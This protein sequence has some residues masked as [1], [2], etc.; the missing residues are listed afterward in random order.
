MPPEYMIRGEISNKHDIF[1]LGVIII[2]II[3]GPEGYSKYRDTTTPQ[4]FIELVREFYVYDM[5]GSIDL[6]APR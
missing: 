4:E 3:T 5:L 1:S 2:E 6:Y